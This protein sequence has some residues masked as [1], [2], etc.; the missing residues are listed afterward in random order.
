MARMNF[1]GF[2]RRAVPTAAALA[3]LALGLT[4]FAGCGGNGEASQEEGKT[5]D[6]LQGSSREQQVNV[7]VE[8]LAPRPF[9][10][11]LLLVGE[12]RSQNDAVISAQAAG[13][14][15]RVVADRGS[16]VRAGDTLLVLDSRRYRAAYEAAAA[17]AENVRLDCEMADRLYQNGQGISESDWKK[18]RNGLKMAEAA[19]ANARIDLEN[20]FVTAPQSG[21]VAERFVDL[22][23][24]VSPGVPLIQLLQG[25]LKVRCG[26]PENQSA[27]AQRG[28][29]ARVRVLEAGIESAARVDWV[30]SA[31]D[32]ATRTLPLELRLEDNGSL[33]PGMA[34]QVELQRAHGALSIVI[35]VNVAQ[36]AAD[37]VFVFVEE[38]GRAVRRDITLGE[39]NGD[40]V[41]VLSGLKAGEHLVVS[42]YR[43]L[44]E[45]Q[46]LAVVAPAESAERAGK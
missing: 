5:K 10:S 31:L 8:A 21:T 41:E 28:M 40:Q 19:L 6:V 42:G 7:A 11:R 45:G 34:C 3:A 44:S 33:R 38:K 36:A 16:R 18:A 4:Q 9:S 22:G 24:L 37:K 17:Q 29:T 1:G 14:L 15:Q 23:E 35:P 25:G 27:G 32:G 2:R 20:C 46:A 12:V 13:T 26:L 43:G 39:R 30:G